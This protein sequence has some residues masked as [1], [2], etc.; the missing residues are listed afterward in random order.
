M[1]AT[2]VI[3]ELRQGQKGGYEPRGAACRLWSNRDHEVIIA[4]PS[5]TGKTLACCH[6]L[7]GL[8]WHFP[9]SQAVMIRK[10]L[11]SL[12]PTVFQTYKRIL[13]DETP[14]VFYGGNKPEWADYP[15]GSRL[16]FAGMD[17]PQKALSSERDFIY[18]NQA[19]E[20]VLNDWEVLTTRATGRGGHAPFAQV[21]GDCNPAQP[22]HWIKT[23]EGL[24]LLES[25]HEDNPTLFDEAGNRT[26]QGEISLSILDKL[27]GVRKERLRYGRWVQAEG[28]VYEEWDRAIHLIDRFDIPQ[29]WPRTWVIDF[30]YTNPF[31]W[32][33]WAQ[34]P[35]GRLYLYRQI[36]MTQCLVEDH[37]KQILQVT[38]GEPKPVKV[39]C[40]H[41]AEDRATLD[42]HLAL[43]HWMMTTPA[44]KSVSDGIQAVQSRLR[45]AG[46]GRPRV[47]ILRDSL[48][49]TDEGLREA[50]KPVCTEDEFEVYSWP[51]AA[52]G[53]PIKEVP[54]KDND[55]G[56]DMLRYRIA[57][58]DLNQKRVGRAA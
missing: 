15:N 19:E 53:K 51:K 56:M 36:Y 58:A 57:D 45:P 13:G 4:G 30:G 10:T 37:A 22:T 6:K 39:I 7:D 34:D 35:D 41:D 26:P 1:S 40:D 16:Y 3:A 18:V 38:Q 17:N 48:V 11:N 9:G 2:Y 27:T 50:R 49:K 46:D 5:E 28:V 54:V 14:V 23:R 12:Y 29:D 33:A 44:Y 55:H 47:Y 20:L 24:T 32:G 31:V 43:M 25:R 8:L 21:I 52:D 42:R